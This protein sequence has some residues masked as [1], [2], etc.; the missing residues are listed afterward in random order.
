MREVSDKDKLFL[1]RAIIKIAA[2]H[3]ML[4]KPCGEGDFLALYVADCGARHTVP[5]SFKFGQGT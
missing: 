5:D 1:G 2:D 3:G 4:V